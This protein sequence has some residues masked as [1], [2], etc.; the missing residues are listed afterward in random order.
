MSVVIELLPA[1]GPVLLVGGGQVALRKARNLAEGG[2]ITTVIAPDALP[3]IPALPGVTLVAREFADADI[4]DALPPWTLVIACTSSREV[5]RRT[6][7][8][9]RER[10]VPV[11]VAD[12]QAESTFFTPAILRDGG[13]QVAV[14]TGGADPRLARQVRERIAGAIGTGWDEVVA[15]A[16]RE[17]R[18]RLGR[19]TSPGP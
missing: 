5:N 19:S 15:T 4:T 17:R 11:L 6:G 7:L 9:A 1:A 2:F 18:E 14:S 8:L 16:G 10:G 12:A 3:E 13:L